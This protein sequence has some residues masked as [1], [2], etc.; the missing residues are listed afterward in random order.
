[1]TETSSDSSDSSEDDNEENKREF[2]RGIN[3]MRK[4]LKC[5]DTCIKNIRT[6]DFNYSVKDLLTSVIPKRSHVDIDSQSNTENKPVPLKVG[7]NFK[8]RKYK[9]SECGLERKLKN[10]I[11]SHINKVHR[12]ELL[13]CDICTFKSF[14]KDSIRIHKYLRCKPKS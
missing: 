9:C 5:I 14:S 11:L 12:K 13:S 8:E 1:M 7:E 3:L 6:D 10:S 4:G 2:R